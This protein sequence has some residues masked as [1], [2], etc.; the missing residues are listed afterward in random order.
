MSQKIVVVVIIVVVV[1]A[2]G[3]V[4]IV[5]LRQ[6]TE[7]LPV[8]QPPRQ[9]TEADKLLDRLGTDPNRREVTEEDRENARESMGTNPN[10]R[11]VTEQERKEAIETLGLHPLDE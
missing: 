4:F 10:K 3:F 11:Q 9:E 8:V 7:E 2:A 1:L 6:S 5:Q